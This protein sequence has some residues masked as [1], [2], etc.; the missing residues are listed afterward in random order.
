MRSVAASHTSITVST[1][2]ERPACP[3]CGDL[4]YAAV[5][6]RFL[7][8]GLLCNTWS[9]DVCEHEFRTSVEIPDAE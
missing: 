4:L 3:N 5:G 6:T 1:F 2:I 9:C 8:H 7:G